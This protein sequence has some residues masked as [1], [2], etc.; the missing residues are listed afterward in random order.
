MELQAVIEGLRTLKEPCRVVVK[1]DSSYLKNGITK[2]IRGWKRKG[3]QRGVKGSSEREE[4]KNRD[5]WEQI[6]QLIAPHNVRCEWIKGHSTDA[7]NNRCDVLANAS[8][9][10]LV[11]PA[12]VREISGDS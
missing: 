1:T 6:D 3:W 10:L 12:R 8:A 2:W 11:D 5:L 4:I 9:R 7:D